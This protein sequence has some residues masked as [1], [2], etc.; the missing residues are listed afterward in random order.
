V[1]LA[2]LDRA[3]DPKLRRLADIGFEEAWKLTHPVTTNQERF[4][5]EQLD[6]MRGLGLAGV[7]PGAPDV[8]YAFLRCQQVR[9]ALEGP[10]EGL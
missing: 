3:Q 4:Y 10:G 7:R 2:R 8:W 6:H 1:W 9:R 5:D